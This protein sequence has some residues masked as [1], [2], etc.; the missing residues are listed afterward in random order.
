MAAKLYNST[1]IPLFSILLPILASP[2]HSLSTVSISE[3]SDR[4]LIC[5]LQGIPGGT[6]PSLNCTSFPAGGIRINTEIRNTIPF[7]GIVSGDGFLCAL[8]A[9]TSSP[10]S[11][12]GCWRFSPDG[13]ATRNL[14]QIYKGPTIKDLDS[15]NE[16]I[17]G[18][19]NGTNR[20][21]CWQWRKFNYSGSRN[22]SLSTVTVGDDYVCGLSSSKGE[23]FCWGDNSGINDRIPE[24]AYRLVKA[25]P[26]HACAISVNDTLRCWGDSPAPDSVMPAAHFTSLALGENRTCGLWSNGTVTCWGSGGFTL[27]TALR[28]INFVAIEAKR[29]VFCGVASSNSSLFCWGNGYL[30]SNPIVFD[31]V[32]PGPCMSSSSCCCRSMILSSSFCSSGYSICQPCTGKCGDFGLEPS[33]SDPSPPL[34]RGSSGVDGQM[35]AFLVVGCVGS[36]SFLLVCGF[37][38]FRYCKG[39]V[40]RVHDSGRLDTSES[41]HGSSPDRSTRP[42]PVLTK[43][44]SHMFSAGNRT[45][46]EEFS[47]Q[48]LAEATDNFSP[49]F[50]VGIGSF[51]SVYRAC[52]DDGREVAIKRAEISM[53]SGGGTARRQQDRD[54]AFV[55]ELESMSRLNHKNLVKL[56]GFCEDGDELILVYEYIDD[57]SLHDHL[58]Q[59]SHSS[60]ATSSWQGRLKVALDA[61]RGIEYLHVYAVPPVIHRD[62]KSSNILLSS[63]GTAKVSDFG[64][65]LS[66]PEDDDSHLSLHAAGTVGYVDPEYYRM[67]HLTPK[68]DVYS[69]GVVLLELLS[70]YRAI[71]KNENGVPRNVVDVVVPFIVH[72]EIH[73][74]LDPKVPPPTPFEIEAVAFVGYL[75]ADCVRLEGRDRPTSTEVIDRLERALYAC[76]AQTRHGSS[77]SDSIVVLDSFHS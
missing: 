43:R 63:D 76:V 21:G 3:T 14:R 57:G 54:K 67:Q 42:Q 47:L 77:M 71:H 51:G 70:G 34:G 26:R 35:M 7:S 31:N 61:A 15:G 40:I 59:F 1:I 73:R 5:A 66:G 4:T 12:I 32:L 46:L 69:F 39:K 74:V 2:A 13:T 48:T 41:N 64:L 44:L 8:M 18:V 37:L 33:A 28:G 24:G 17:C 60:P 10:V 65:S 11:I 45:H 27:P 9:S 56:Y 55:N 30:D 36:A 52:L 49:E 72:N 68:S 6:S 62:I 75:A 25:G 23:I 20:L 53:T 29:S 38:V 58:H 19:F 22:A 50:K 16:R